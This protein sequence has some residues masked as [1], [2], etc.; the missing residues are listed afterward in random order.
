[1]NFSSL[2]RFTW[3]VLPLVGAGGLVG[4]CSKDEACPFGTQHCSLDNTCRDLMNDANSCGACNVVCASGICCNGVCVDDPSQ[5]S[6]EPPVGCGAGTMDCAGNGTCVNLLSDPT[7]C[8]A[9]GTTCAPGQAC[10]GGNCSGACAANELNCDGA[11]INPNINP[12]HCGA[13]GNAC[14]STQACQNGTC[15]CTNPQ[16]T[17][18]GTWCGSTQFNAQHCGS[19]DNVCTSDQSCNNGVCENGL[20]TGDPIEMCQSG[21]SNSFMPVAGSRYSV[22]TNKWGSGAGEVCITTDFTDSFWISKSTLNTSNFDPAGYPSIFFGCHY[23]TCTQSGGEIPKALSQ[24]T[25]ARS[26]WSTKEASGSYNIAYDIWVLPSCTADG[27]DGGG[28]EMMIWLTSS[29]NVNPAG[30]GAGQA[31]LG[32]V[33]YN[34]NQGHVSS[35]NYL[36]YRRTST[37]TSVTDLDLKAFLDDA[38]S[39]GSA[40]QGWCLTGVEAGFEVWNGGSGLRTDS[41]S[42]TVN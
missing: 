34:V 23:S 15:A 4:A 11:C 21:T 17:A 6:A 1:M 14:G 2:L 22:Q 32:G 18:C 40:Q 28:L 37:T 35:W 3:I 31:N 5:C 20:G 16:W 39:R 42:V 7:N 33:S 27:P 8:G 12:S 13:C 30:S 26:S 25:S 24:I 29:G 9:C 38:V 19:C 36:A 10:S 41:F